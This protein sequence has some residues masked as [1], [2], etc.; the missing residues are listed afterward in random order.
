MIYKIFFI[1]LPKPDAQASKTPI[2]HLAYL[3]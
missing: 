2:A 3:V 1:F